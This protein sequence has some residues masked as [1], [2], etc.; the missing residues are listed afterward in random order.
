MQTL[1]PLPPIQK[2]LPPGVG[3][4]SSALDI[5]MLEK[6]DS[7]RKSVEGGTSDFVKGTV[8]PGLDSFGASLKTIGGNLLVNLLLGTAAIVFL[9]VAITGSVPQIKKPDL[10]GGEE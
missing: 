4:N 3:P 1:P 7:I 2:N 10:N 5:S 6:I 9:A 8:Q